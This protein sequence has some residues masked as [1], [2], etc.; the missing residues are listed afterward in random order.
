M[1]ARVQVVFTPELALDLYAEPFVSSGRF[2]GFGELPRPRSRALSVYGRDLGTIERDPGADAYAIR[3]G[4]DAFDIEDPD[5]TALSFRSTAV[6]RW[7]IWPGSTLFAVWQANRADELG[8]PD[9]VTP[10]AWGEAL[11][12]P[13]SQTLALKLAYWWPAD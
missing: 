10:L 5:F 1:Q 11:R 3:A 9:P 4:G 13:G 7:E 8:M 2:H 12:S 6:L